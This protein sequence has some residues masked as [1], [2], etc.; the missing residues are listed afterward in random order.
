[1]KC[2]LCGNEKDVIYYEITWTVRITTGFKIFGWFCDVHR[3]DYS[4]KMN[5]KT[6]KFVMECF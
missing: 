1:M 4:D 2:Y 5:N 6:V 3:N